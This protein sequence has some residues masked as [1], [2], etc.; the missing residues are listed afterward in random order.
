M[1]QY[2]ELGYVTGTHVLWWFFILKL[3]KKISTEEF[4]M[5]FVFENTEYLYLYLMLPTGHVI[6]SVLTCFC[7]SY[8][9]EYLVINMCI[10]V[11]LCERGVGLSLWY[12]GLNVY[13]NKVMIIII[14]ASKK[15][16]LT[17]NGEMT[18]LPASF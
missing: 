13:E 1:P 3:Y 5:V 16:E 4:N 18:Q 11:M 8:F 12:E 2:V 6:I 15:Y 10:C 7:F 14:L 9:D 17:E